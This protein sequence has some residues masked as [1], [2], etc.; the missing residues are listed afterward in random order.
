MSLVKDKVLLTFSLTKEEIDVLNEHFNK[1]GAKP[2]VVIES[3]MSNCTLKE[4]LQGEDKNYSK[5]QL[6][7][8]KVIIFNNFEGENLHKAVTQVRAL[9]QSRPILATITPVSINMKFK[10]VLEHLIEEREFHKKNS[11]NKI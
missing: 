2:C 4:I 8:E 1:E 5:E 11:K 7:L 3:S 10:D 9:L 6:P